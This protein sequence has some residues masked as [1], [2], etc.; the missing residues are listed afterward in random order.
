LAWSPLTII[1]IQAFLR[2]AYHLYQGAGA[3]GGNLVMGLIFGWYYHRSGRLAPL[4]A[5]H[6][7]ID[8]VAF[9]GYPLISANVAE[10]L[11]FTL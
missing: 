3:F 10:T 11:G 7:L 8:A 4:I 6:T 5:A 1:L 9:V 2:G